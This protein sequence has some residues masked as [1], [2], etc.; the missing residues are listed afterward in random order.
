MLN[1]KIKKPEGQRIWI[2]CIAEEFDPEGRL[3]RE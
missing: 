1:N 3:E 2:T